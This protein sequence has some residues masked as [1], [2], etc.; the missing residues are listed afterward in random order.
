MTTDEVADRRTAALQ[1][2]AYAGWPVAVSAP[3][4]LAEVWAEMDAQG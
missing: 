4:I 3:G 2:T 1:L